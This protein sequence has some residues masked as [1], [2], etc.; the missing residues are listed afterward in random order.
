MIFRFIDKKV[1]HVVV[2]VSMMICA[3]LNKVYVRAFSSARFSTFSSSQ[4]RLWRSSSSS[5]IPN[6]LAVYSFSYSDSNRRNRYVLPRCYSLQQDNQSISEELEESRLGKKAARAKSKLADK[7]R[8]LKL[9]ELLNSSNVDGSFEVPS[10]YAVKVSV[11]K[12]LR[13]ELK[14]NGREKRGRVF[15]GVGSEGSQTLKGLKMELHSFF[16]SLRKSS[17]TLSAALPEVDEDGS[18]LAPVDD[19]GYNAYPGT[20]QYWNIATDEDVLESFE[21]VKA[22]A[23]INPLM[24]RPSI[25]IHVQKDPNA[26]PPPPPPQ[27]L[28]GMDDPSVTESMTM[29]SFYAFPPPLR[30]KDYGIEDPEEFSIRLRKLWKPFGALGRVYVAREGV[31][32]QMAIPTNV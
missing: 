3:T 4:T 17:F 19:E 7:E 6:D 14:M 16:R 10:L 20:L 12:E 25:L 15:I 22:F 5:N 26:P 30:Y 32:A 31:N 23:D 1:L 29:L 24:K 13:E 28:E 9:K 8:N 27:Y 21:K 2:I 18:I 11:C